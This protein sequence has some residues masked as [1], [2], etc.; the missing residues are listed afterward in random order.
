MTASCPLSFQLLS[1]Q[2]LWLPKSPRPHPHSCKFSFAPHL[3]F[4]VFLGLAPSRMPCLR[5][6]HLLLSPIPHCCQLTCLPKSQICSVCASLYRD[7]VAPYYLQRK[8]PKPQHTQAKTLFDLTQA[9]SNPSLLLT[10]QPPPQ[11]TPTALLSSAMSIPS[12]GPE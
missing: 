6:G 11:H 7:S 5:C 3:S 4:L 9:C 1:L 8:V 12:P 10:H 2:V